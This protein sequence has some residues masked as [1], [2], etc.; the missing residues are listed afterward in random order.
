MQ[1]TLGDFQETATFNILAI[2]SIFGVHL[3]LKNFFWSILVGGQQRIYLARIF[4]PGL[5][6]FDR[7]ISNNFNILSTVYDKSK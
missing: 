1:R 3:G 4:Q 7:F 5:K 6:S 2:L